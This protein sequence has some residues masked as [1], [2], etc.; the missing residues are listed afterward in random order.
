MKRSAFDENRDQRIADHVSATDQ[1]LMCRAQGCPLCWSVNAEGRVHLCSAHAW[2]DPEDW[3]RITARLQDQHA[4]AANRAARPRVPAQ[5]ISAEEKRA[6]G[7]KLRQAVRRIEIGKRWAHRLQGREQ[8]GEKLSEAQRSMWRDAL[9]VK[10]Q[11]AQD[12]P[13]ELPR[14]IAPL[15]EHRAEEIPW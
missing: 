7:Q 9:G 10:D 1:A 15:P 11:P 3:P 2:S 6:I 13:F 12:D 8:A 4:R 14:Q 5:P